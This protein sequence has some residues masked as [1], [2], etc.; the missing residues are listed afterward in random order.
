MTLSDYIFKHLWPPFTVYCLICQLQHLLCLRQRFFKN[1]K[2]APTELSVTHQ[3]IR[4]L[5]LGSPSDKVHGF[6]SHGLGLHRPKFASLSIII[7][8]CKNCN[9][10]CK[11]NYEF[12]INFFLIMSNTSRQAC[13]LTASLVPDS[14]NLYTSVLPFMH[15]PV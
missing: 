9:S 8:N 2:K 11:K 4:L 5:L 13:F 3:K 14:C 10:F 15:T 12:L 1:Q 6:Q 7:Q